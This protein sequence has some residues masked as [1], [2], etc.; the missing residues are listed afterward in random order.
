[1]SFI[2]RIAPIRRIVHHVGEITEF[3]QRVA[4]LCEPGVWFWDCSDLD[5]IRIDR[6]KER[7]R[8]TTAWERRED[9]TVWLLVRRVRR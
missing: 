8:M 3:W 6:E 7:G 9:T 4:V 2:P 5:R 1:M